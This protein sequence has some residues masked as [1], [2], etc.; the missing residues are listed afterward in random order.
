MHVTLNSLWFTENS[1]QAQIW[2]HILFYSAF[3]V[4]FMF[5]GCIICVSIWHSVFATDSGLKIKHALSWLRYFKK[6]I[7]KSKELVMRS[8]ERRQ[9][10]LLPITKSWIWNINFLR[11]WFSLLPSISPVVSEEIVYPLNCDENKFTFSI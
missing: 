2:V 4:T 5:F 1:W 6:Q 3:Y 8:G 7:L 9:S 11:L 10:Q